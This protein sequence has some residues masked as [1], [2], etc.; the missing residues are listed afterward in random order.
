[1]ITRDATRNESWAVFGQFSWRPD[2]LSRKLEIV[3]GIRYTRDT[4]E[5][6]VVDNGSVSYA[7]GASSYTQVSNPVLQ[8]GNGQLEGSKTTPGLSVLYHFDDQMM[9]YG[10]IAR[11]YRTGGFNMAD[12]NLARALTGFAPET[13]TSKELGFKGQFL[14]SRLR[15]NLA[16]FVMDYKDQQMQLSVPSSTGGYSAIIANAGNSQIKGFELDAVYAVTK[17]LRLGL[18]WTRLD[19]TY[20]KVVA[21]GT[22]TNVASRFRRTLPKNNYTVNVDYR[23]PDLGLPGKLEGHLDYTHMDAQSG[24]TT[25]GIT[26][27]GVFAGYTTTGFAEL[28]LTP[29]YSVWNG[30]LA[31]NGISAGPNGLGDVSVGLW[32]KN[33]TDKKYL[34]Y[35][36]AGSPFGGIT[37]AAL[38]VWAPRRTVGV[39][40][41]YRF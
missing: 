6:R 41:I 30:R 35:V 14:E 19:L 33:L 37:G 17:N 36:M 15:T 9:G 22:S 18:S 12:S 28:D 39:D 1:M 29:A 3:P 23:F 13:L 32:A 26:Q 2:I 7:L 8:S 25:D 10:K 11:G 16:Y 31:L 4:R 5:V 34:S 40:V 20:K 21:P 27:G 24:S 38:G